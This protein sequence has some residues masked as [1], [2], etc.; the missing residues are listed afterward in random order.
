M[1]IDAGPLSY[2]VVII[3]LF[4][5]GLIFGVAARK[6]AISVVLIIVGIILA[7]FIGL[8]LPFLSNSGSLIVHLETFI[9]NAA[10]RFGQ[11]IYA[12]PILWIIGFIVGLFV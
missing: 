5:D 7:S 3:L 8:S 4:F 2:L 11:I 10:R 1:A 9:A 12:F 6:G